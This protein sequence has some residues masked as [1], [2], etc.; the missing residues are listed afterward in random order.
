MAASHQIRAQGASAIEA[1]LFGL[2]QAFGDIS[3]LMG[4]IALYGESS[5]IERFETEIAPDGSRWSQSIRARTEGGKTLTDNAILKNSITPESG[6][7]YAAWGSNIIYAGIHNN[8]GTIRAKNAKHLSF[9]LPGG[10]GFRKVEAV[11]I[12]QREF[13]GL[14]SEDNVEIIALAE[15]YAIAVAPGI[16][17]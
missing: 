2:V 5:T 10:L 3:P 13:L 7:D 17:R 9:G 15:D 8:G 6:S 1:Q 12:P 11:D 4:D 14:S 16:E